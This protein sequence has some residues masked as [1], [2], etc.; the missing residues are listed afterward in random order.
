MRVLCGAVAVAAV[1]GLVGCGDGSGGDAG[2]S[3]TAR[4]TAPTRAPGAGEVPRAPDAPA[5]RAV[6]GPARAPRD[7][8]ARTLV[9]RPLRDAQAL[10][11]VR[12]CA[13]RV[14]ERDGEG[15]ARTDDLRPER[16]NVVVRGGRVVAVDGVG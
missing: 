5:C 3:T 8:D 7:F 13:V 2:R 10:A 4:S 15:L 16:A 12:G 1:I 14:V 11:A 9:G 6:A